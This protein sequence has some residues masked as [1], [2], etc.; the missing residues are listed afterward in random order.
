MKDLLMHL[1]II[2]VAFFVLYAGLSLLIGIGNTP[3]PTPLVA[4]G[5]LFSFVVTGLSALLLTIACI[6]LPC[7]ITDA[8]RNR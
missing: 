4:M 1:V 6:F 5:I 8:W 7:H 3:N 2:A